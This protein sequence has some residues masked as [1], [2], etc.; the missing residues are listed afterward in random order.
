MDKKCIKGLSSAK[1]LQELEEGPHSGPYLQ[2]TLIE[3]FH[4]YSLLI[5]RSSVAIVF[6]E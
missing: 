5:N 4:Q 2:V 1:V 3:D 6:L